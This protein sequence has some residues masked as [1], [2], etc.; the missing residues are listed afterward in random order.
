MQWL[1][2]LFTSK[3][4]VNGPWASP[5]YSLVTNPTPM[6][7][8]WL[9]SSSPVTS[10]TSSFIFLLLSLAVPSASK[11]LPPA[12]LLANCLL[13][14]GFGHMPL[15]HDVCF[16]IE[17]QLGYHILKNLFRTNWF[18]A[19]SPGFIVFL[20]LFSFYLFIYLWLC[21]VSASIHWH[22]TEADTVV[23]E[24]AKNSFIALLGKGS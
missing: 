5:S 21:Q 15:Y 16:W 9:S 23:G 20:F 3:I 19:L 17:I 24:A 12:I 7:L 1:P 10:L 13:L 11:V 18:S 4:L 8:Y 2:I 22:Q 6:K 14:Q